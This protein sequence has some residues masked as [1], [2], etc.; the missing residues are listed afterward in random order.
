MTRKATIV[1]GVTAT[2]ATPK[3]G[4]LVSKLVKQGHDV[5]VAMLESAQELILPIKL[6]GLS[7]NPVITKVE[8][9]TPER[10]KNAAREKHEKKK[11]QLT[12]LLADKWSSTVLGE[13]SPCDFFTGGFPLDEIEIL[14]PENTKLTKAL[15]RTLAFVF[16]DLV[17]FDS[18]DS[19]VLEE[20]DNIRNAFYNDYAEELSKLDFERVFL[21]NE[22]YDWRC[23]VADLAQRADL[24][25]VAPANANVI[26]DL[27]LGLGESPITEIARITSAPLLIAPALSKK[28]WNHPPTQTNVRTLKSRRRVQVIEPRDKM[29]SD[30]YRVIAENWNVDEVVASAQK[31]LA[32]RE[33]DSKT[34]RR[35]S[36]PTQIRLVQL[37]D[38]LAAVVGSKALLPNEL[39]HRLWTYI[40]RHGCQ[41]RKLRRVINADQKLIAAFRLM[42]PVGT[43][44]SQVSIYEMTKLVFRAT[45]SHRYFS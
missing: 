3:A 2:F 20:M 45:S 24:L 29:I 43:S 27:A 26:A 39:A 21:E 13:L 33:I 19:P 4:D 44:K 12:D 38:K 9:L 23:D 1:V 16:E 15:L 35:R 32:A 31:L 18:P 17:P 7:G 5:H 36:L 14:V 6:L 42:G 11:K 28:S 8:Y 22:T 37:N 41:D 34:N 40:K 10:Q 30:H 25:I